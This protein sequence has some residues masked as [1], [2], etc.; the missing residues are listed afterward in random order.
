MR[1]IITAGRW[2]YLIS[3]L[4][5]NILGMSDRWICFISYLT[6]NSLGILY[7]NSGTI[8]QIHSIVKWLRKKLSWS[9]ALW[10]CFLAM[11]CPLP[12]KTSKSS[13]RILVVPKNHHLKSSVLYRMHFNCY[14]FATNNYKIHSHPCSGTVWRNFL[15]I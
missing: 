6:I 1:P 2:V 14:Y 15:N 9:G 8:G 12:Y 3:Y 13:G 7:L 5:I 10:L 11:R 4:T